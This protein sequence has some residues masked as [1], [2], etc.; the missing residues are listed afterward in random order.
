MGDAYADRVD[1]VA[2]H[3]RTHLDGE[4]TLDALARRAHFSP[5][6]FH[7]IFKA[8]T[9]ETLGEFVRRARLERAV[10]L[11]RGAP[12]RT[13]TGIAYEV[14]YS[15]PSDLS[16]VFKQVY[17]IAP[18]RWDRISRLDGTPGHK[19]SDALP[20]GPPTAPVIRH[21]PPARVAYVRLRKL[22]E[23]PNVFRDGYAALTAW[24]DEHEI[25]WRTLP[26]IGQTW[27]SELATPL[28]QVVYDLG[29]PVSEDVQPDETVGIHALPAVKA[30]E[31][32]CRTLPEI[33][34][35]WDHLYEVWLPASDYEPDDVP[36][37]KRFVET[38]EAFGA[39]AWHVDCSIALRPRRT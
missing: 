37:I 15:A 3:I 28:D 16:R 29:F 14:G 20:A 12:G 25:A 22:W 36:P 30:V 11:M 17:G 21:H 39:D 27:D 38:P 2:D 31:I 26:L 8:R 10:Y 32:R 24:C 4:L 1:L 33:A 6:H 35:A 9:G 5:Y 19:A 34:A 7:R 23:D 18:S 13:L